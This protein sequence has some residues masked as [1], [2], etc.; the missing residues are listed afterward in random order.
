MKHHGDAHVT[1]LEHNDWTKKHVNH[2]E[3]VVDWLLFASI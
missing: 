1:S 3:L 2:L